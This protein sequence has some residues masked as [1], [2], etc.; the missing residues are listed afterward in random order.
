MTFQWELICE[1]ERIV[2]LILTIQMAGVLVGAPVF[3]QL[4]DTF[5][6]KWV[7]RASSL[8]YEFQKV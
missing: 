6:R 4:G 2:Y 5:G 3:G 8:S 7:S 1:R